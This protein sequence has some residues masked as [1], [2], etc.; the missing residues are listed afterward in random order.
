MSS[1]WSEELQRD[2]VRIAE[3][4]ARAIGGVDD[5]AVRQAQL[6]QSCLPIRQIRSVGAR[7]RQVIQTDPALVEGLIARWIGEL[8]E[9][10]QGLTD[11]PDDMAEGSGIFVEDRCRAE[12]RPVPGDT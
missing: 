10:H 7:E 4:Q 2:V 5:P 6:V 12:Q 9:P 8:V 3:R 1:W 11:K